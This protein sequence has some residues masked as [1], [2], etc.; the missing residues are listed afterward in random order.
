MQNDKRQTKK[1]KPIEKL[2]NELF[3]LDKEDNERLVEQYATQ[4]AKAR[5]YNRRQTMITCARANNVIL[6]NIV[7]FGQVHQNATIKHNKLA[8]LEPKLT[9][10]CSCC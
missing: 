6:Y 2:L 9:I 10:L 8:A 7:D 3:S 4:P 1:E 5:N